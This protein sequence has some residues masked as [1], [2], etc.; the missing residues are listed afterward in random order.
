M[1]G[2]SGVGEGPRRGGAVL[3]SGACKCK[4]CAMLAVAE[5]QAAAEMH[6]QQAGRKCEARDAEESQRKQEDLARGVR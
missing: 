1:A 5:L 6:R 4:Y 2:G 3:V